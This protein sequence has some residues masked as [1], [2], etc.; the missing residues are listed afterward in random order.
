[1][2][3]RV[4]PTVLALL[5][6]LAY[7]CFFILPETHHAVLLYFGELEA[8]VKPGFNVKLPVVHTVK[9]FDGRLQSIVQT[10]S[11]YLT[12]EKEFLTV[13]FF[14]NYRVVDPARY[15]ESTGGNQRRLRSLLIERVD[16]GMRNEF[17]SRSK[18]EVISGERDALLRDLLAE[19][20]AV[21]TA[22]YGVK[23]AAINVIRIDL[24]EQASSSVYNRM[25]AE[26]QR[27]ANEARAEGREISEKL[28][29]EA[30]R[31][32]AIILAEAYRTSEVLRG[33]GDATAA[34]I[35]AQAYSRDPEFY[36]YVR[37]LTAYQKSFESGSDIMVL[38]PDSE[39]F[40][41]FGTQQ[42]GSKAHN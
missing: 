14:I 7:N 31:K 30:D 39:F 24:P 33:E 38:E 4:M 2:T 28:K 19:V 3:Q 37:S 6:I 16:G 26:R 25:I 27:L 36:D 22:E 41:F 29:S 11:S 15:Y 10:E 8:E 18:A 23:L 34:G 21:A 12:D 35:Y 13:D 1:M 17:G 40:K 9:K 42:E 32:K 5:L 20:N